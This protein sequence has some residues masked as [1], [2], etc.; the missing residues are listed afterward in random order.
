MNKL[1]ILSVVRLILLTGLLSLF[2]ACGSTSDGEAPRVSLQEFK[3]TEGNSKISEAAE[4]Y[5]AIPEQ[6]KNVP[7]EQIKSQIEITDYMVMKGAATN[8]GTEDMNADY[9]SE[10]DITGKS[11]GAGGAAIA[12]EPPKNKR[13]REALAQYTNKL[14]SLEGV[15]QQYGAQKTS[16]L[17]IKERTPGK[18]E[19]WF[20]DK[21]RKPCRYQALLLYNGPE[22]KGDTLFK[23]DDTIKFWGVIIGEEIKKLRSTGN[24]KRYPKIIVMDLEV[25][26]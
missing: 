8:A 20:C 25:S 5:W 23:L 18:Y 26:S 22:G 3:E 12:K 13:D 15:V 9:L 24:I 2:F 17:Y 4:A 14:I 6:Y 7:I 10:S 21:T 11:K 19:I 1:S 16:P